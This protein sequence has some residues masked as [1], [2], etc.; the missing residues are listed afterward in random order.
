MLK[1]KVEVSLFFYVILDIAVIVLSFY[2][3][4]YFRAMLFS[5]VLLREA[6]R[7]G[8]YMWFL[9]T[10]VPLWVLL[11]AYERAYFSL[12]RK[13]LK[14]LIIPTTKAVLEGFLIVL[15]VLFFAKI[16]AKSRLFFIVFAV[17]NILLL[18]FVR[19]LTYLVQA[20]IF[21]N[22][23]FYH[24]VLIVG[25]GRK[26]NEVGQFFKGHSHWGMKIEGFLN[27]ANEKPVVEKGKIIGSINDL[28][29]LLRSL[30]IDW[31][32]FTLP[33][34]ESNTMM[35]GIKICKELGVLASC[36]ISEFFPSED[37]NLSLEIYG[38][39]P[40]V[41][42]RT[43]S[44]KK[45]ELLLKGILDRLLGATMLIAFLPLYAGVALAIKLTSKGAVLFKQERC[46]VNG[47]RF[48]FYKFRT[49]VSDAE[50]KKEGLSHL[51]PKKIVFKITN[52]PR[53]TKVG[54]FLRR[55]SI[56]ELPQLFNVLRGDMSF[57]GPRPP[58]PD[59]VNMYE[60]W[61]RRKLSMKPGLTCLWQVNGRA[62]LDFDEW[63]KLDLEYIDT[64]SLSLDMKILARTIPA[65]LSRKGAY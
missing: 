53:I 41:N 16:F 6:W 13:S 11:L 32:V 31:V 21:R 40:L 61:Q 29:S 17:S 52:D 1:E 20:R 22:P 49:M 3:A 23:P 25:T 15:A 56:D 64:W 7:L 45:W 19:W 65:V 30:P 9:W 24:N 38:N 51:N 8:S 33:F 18:L 28:S 58:V 63:L 54:K 42:F 36:L 39:L 27:I 37:A 4:F 2:G 12:E 44:V 5:N 50:S 46:G 34:R 55:S 26:A 35:K 43:T 10:V 62:E 48:I 60:D 47:R 59:E 14:D 57:V